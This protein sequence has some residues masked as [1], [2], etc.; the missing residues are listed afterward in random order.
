MFWALLPVPSTTKVSPARAS[1]DRPTFTLI[2]PLA[3]SAVLSTALSSPSVVIWMVTFLVASTASGPKLE[4]SR[5]AVSVASGVALLAASFKVALTV[6]LAPSAGAANVVVTLPAALAAA[7][8]VMFLLVVPSVTVT[9]SP[10]ATKAPLKAALTVTVALPPSSAR[11]MKP[12]LLPSVSMVSAK[13]APPLGSV[14]S[15]VALS[16]PTAEALLAWSTNCACTLSVLPLAGAVISRVTLP[17]VMFAAVRVMFS[18]TPLTVTLSV[19][20]ALA[21]VGIEMFTPTVPLS[22]EPLMKP[23]LL[24]S[25]V[26]VTTGAPAMVLRMV[27]LSRASGVGLA[28][29][30]ASLMLAVT[31]N[32]VLSP[33]L[34]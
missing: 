29:P 33:V 9:T 27:A 2:L 34:V 30:A 22:S 23:S 5:R 4:V 3:S 20:P 19:S 18:S 31:V 10:T 12:S 32:V 25:S 16:W 6:M 11:L 13:A 21:A 28:L 1:A 14:V 8:T 15:M 7:S 24:P 26:M 17:A